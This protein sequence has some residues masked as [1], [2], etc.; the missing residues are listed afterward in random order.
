MASKEIALSATFSKDNVLCFSCDI[1][2]SRRNIKAHTN[3]Q[4]PGKPVKV[5]LKGT[6]AK[7]VQICV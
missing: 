5:K 4:H 7:V 1:E 6:E 2:I 3:S